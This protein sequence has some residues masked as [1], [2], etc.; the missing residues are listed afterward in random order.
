MRFIVRFVGVVLAV[1]ACLV[2]SSSAAAGGRGGPA[3]NT[4]VRADLITDA[5]PLGW[6]VVAVAIEYRD[7]INVGAADIPVSAFTVAATVNNATANRTVVD[8]YTSDAPELDRR[9]PRGTPGRYLIIELS[10]DDPNAGALVYAMGRNEPVPLVGAYAVRQTANVVDDR[11]RVLLRASP[12]TITN[13]GVINPIV[14]DF[15]SLSYT[16]SAGTPLKFRL[17]QPQARPDRRRDGFPLVVFLHGGGERG[18]NNISQITANQGAVAF[19]KPER[20]ASDPSY[21]L[22]AQVPVGSSWTTPAVQAALIE[23]IDTLVA[24]LPIDEDRLYLTGLS[25][26]GIGS[27]D[28]LPKYPDKFAGALTIAATGDPSRMPLMVDVPLWATH[29]IDDPTVNYTTGTLALINALEAAGAR[30]V[31]GEWPGN[32]PDR[33]AEAEALRL[34][35]QADAKDSHT[36]LTTYTAGTTPVNAHWSWVPTYLNDVMVDWLFSQDLQDREHDSLR[37]SAPD[38]ATQLAGAAR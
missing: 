16:D 25:L 33:A 27:F 20:Q 8:V 14:D 23:L 7:A 6:K 35:A 3:Q 13:Q 30:V 36:L 24:T 21:V 19:A 4:V 17:F 10:P 1:V 38:A 9:G 29:S 5:H 34:W 26:G 37:F 18:A 12:F 11:G 32:L 28:I 22:A 15:V 31:R 2:A